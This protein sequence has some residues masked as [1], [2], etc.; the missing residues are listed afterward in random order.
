[1]AVTPIDVRRC[2]L[3]AIRLVAYVF[4]II[5]IYFLYTGLVWW[6]YK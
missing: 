3:L 6:R 2:V 1:M 5:L 4:V